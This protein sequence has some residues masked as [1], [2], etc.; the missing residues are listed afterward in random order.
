MSDRSL[1]L[2][3]IKKSIYDF[4]SEG[5]VM[6]ENFGAH[7]I[8][9]ALKPI[10]PVDAERGTSGNVCNVFIKQETFPD[11]VMSRIGI[12]ESGTEKLAR[13]I[14]R[15]ICFNYQIVET[16]G[17]QR[18]VPPSPHN[19]SGLKSGGFNGSDIGIEITGGGL[20]VIVGGEHENETK[21]QMG[22]SER[23]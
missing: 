23:V 11:S 20:G 2:W 15:R 21:H 6:Y 16:C 9:I 17:V 4:F 13:T 19:S 7:V 8:E 14:K 5:G 12:D 3:I 10:S 1:I 18:V 22:K